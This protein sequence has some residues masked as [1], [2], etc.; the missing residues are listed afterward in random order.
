M[1]AKLDLAAKVATGCTRVPVSVDSR[2]AAYYARKYTMAELRTFEAALT[3]ADQY[4][5]QARFLFDAAAWSEHRRKHVGAGADR[6]LGGALTVAD[7][8]AWYAENF[9]AAYTFDGM[10]ACGKDVDG[11]GR[12]CNAAPG[13]EGEC[14]I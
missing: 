11:Q 4:S 3:Y 8:E 1:S 14:M 7:A 5:R 13:H 9:C 10:P 2:T 12:R 6:V